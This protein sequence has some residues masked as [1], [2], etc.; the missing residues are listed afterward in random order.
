MY[1]AKGFDVDASAYF[2]LFNPVVH[3]P[4]GEEVA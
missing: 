3:S 2:R 1:V 4:A